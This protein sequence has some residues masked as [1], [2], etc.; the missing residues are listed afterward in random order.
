MLWAAGQEC[1]QTAVG[2][3]FLPA[4]WPWAAGSPQPSVAA[5]APASA[6]SAGSSGRQRSGVPASRPDCS[7]AC[8]SRDQLAL[9]GPGSVPSQCIHEARDLGYSQG[10]LVSKSPFWVSV[11]PLDNKV[12]THHQCLSAGALL[13]KH[14]V[15]NTLG[16]TRPLNQFLSLYDNHKC[17]KGWYDLKLRNTNLV[18]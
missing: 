13:A 17:L 9:L 12:I 6:G 7:S 14:R 1:P 18:Q 3:S 15:F 5:A 2:W 11:S 4:G 8:G 10:S 16:P